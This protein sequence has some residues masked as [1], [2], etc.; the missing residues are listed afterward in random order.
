MITIKTTITTQ[1]KSP[2]KDFTCYPRLLSLSSIYSSFMPVMQSVTT[3]LTCWKCKVPCGI[4]FSSCMT[5][6]R[7]SN[8]LLWS[9]HTT[10]SIYS[11]SWDFTEMINEGGSR[12]SSPSTLAEQCSG[13]STLSSIMQCN[14]TISDSWKTIKRHR[15]RILSKFYVI[16]FDHWK[17]SITTV[18]EWQ[19]SSAKSSVNMVIV[20]IFGNIWND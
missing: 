20:R 18:E 1:K 17:L 8:T 16:C 15:F 2:R 9:S 12:H 3:A 6:S 5:A 19:Y 14:I 10:A 4:L 11:P 13:K 7:A